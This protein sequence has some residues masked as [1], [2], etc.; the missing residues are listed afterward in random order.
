MSIV[1]VE[2][3]EK[4]GLSKKKKPKALFSKIG[5]I[6]C[7]TVGQNIARMIS[8]SDIEVVFIELSEEIIKHSYVE[9]EQELDRMIDHWGMTNTEKRLILTRIHGSVD[10]KDLKECDLVIDAV[11]SKTREMMVEERKKIFKNIEE[12]VDRHTIIATNSTTVVITELSSELKHNDRCVSLH[13]STT[14]PDANIIEVVRGLFTSDETYELVKKFTRLIQKDAISVEE[15]PGLI[16]VRLYAVLVNE[17][18]EILMEGVGS[19]EDIDK[20]V[21]NSMGLRLGPFEMADK[22]GIDKVVRW[23]DNLYREFG[24]MKYK[25]NPTLK[26]YLRSNNLGRRTGRGFYKY[27]QTGKKIPKT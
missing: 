17:A 16:S 13:F 10:Y 27:D 12:H 9:I 8:M 19:M 23:L 26:K 20:T 1:I 22:I 15:S 21:R 2:P 24:D 7:G 4:Y 6:G 3:V 14:S 18:C 25:A 11:K 5:I